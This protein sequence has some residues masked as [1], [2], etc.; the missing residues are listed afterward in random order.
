VY[1]IFWRSTAGNRNDTTSYVETISK[2]ASDIDIYL[3]SLFTSFKSQ[4]VTRIRPFCTRL[5]ITPGIALSGP[6]LITCCVVSNASKS[7][8]NSLKSYTN[9]ALAP[10]L[11][12][13]VLARTSRDW[14]SH[15]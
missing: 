14:L 7:K 9:D 1:C 2:I 12:L 4:S 11:S 3:L 5:I 8:A 13:S 10:I 15:S 6:H